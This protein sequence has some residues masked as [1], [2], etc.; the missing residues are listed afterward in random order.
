MSGMKRGGGSD[1]DQHKT[2]WKPPDPPG[3]ETHPSNPSHPCASRPACVMLH[4]ARPRLKH[5]RAA[6]ERQ[7]RSVGCDRERGGGGSRPA[8]RQAEKGPPTLSATQLRD[9]GAQ[10]LAR[11]LPHDALALLTQVSSQP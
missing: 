11:K 10:M 4:A 5:Y 7:L 2:Y 8:L 1:A 9:R 6:N 3:D